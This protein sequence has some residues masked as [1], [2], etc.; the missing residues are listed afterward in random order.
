[1]QTSIAVAAAFLANAFVAGDQSAPGW[2][3]D[4]P[5]RIR[6]SGVEYRLVSGPELRRLITGATVSSLDTFTSGD[7]FWRY[8]RNGRTYWNHGH[9]GVPQIGSYRIGRD[10]ICHRISGDEWCDSLFRNVRGDFM[11]VVVA[12][13][14][15]WV[16]RAPERITLSPGRVANPWGLRE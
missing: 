9:R 1:M 13:S 5:H 14:N 15:A 3:V 10:R 4:P 16:S 2:T 8:D 12:A 6:H 11:R 7:N